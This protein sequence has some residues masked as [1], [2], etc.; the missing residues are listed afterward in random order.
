MS[1]Q[2]IRLCI[3]RQH[4]QNMYQSTRC[5]RTPDTVPNER[6]HEGLNLTIDL[7]GPI[8]AIYKTAYV[9]DKQ[10]FILR[11]DESSKKGVEKNCQTTPYQEDDKYSENQ[12]QTKSARR[13]ECT[14]YNSH[15]NTTDG[16]IELKIKIDTIYMNVLM[17]A[18]QPERISYEVNKKKIT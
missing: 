9:R 10:Q 5:L 4:H 12:K 18:K 8:K 16:F 7:C 3:H 17:V 1:K 2:N 14:Q 13:T 15:N 11:G 6:Y